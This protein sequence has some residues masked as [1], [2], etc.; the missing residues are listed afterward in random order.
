MPRI[1]LSAS[2]PPELMLRQSPRNQARWDEFQ[3]VTEAGPDPVD[4]WVV[5]DDLQSPQTQVCPPGN[6]LLVTGE[7]SV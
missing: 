2:F 4:A 1:L 5:Y 6:T 3:F 7:P